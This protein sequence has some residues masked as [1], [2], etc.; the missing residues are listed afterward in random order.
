MDKYADL[1]MGVLLG[2]NFF[3]LFRLRILSLSLL[4]DSL[5]CASWRRLFCI[6]ILGLLIS[7][8]NLH[9]QI[10]PRFGKFSVFLSFFL[11]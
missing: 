6:E 9:V 5:L 3:L 2:D 8:L 4:L 7:F 10:S 11:C 1:L